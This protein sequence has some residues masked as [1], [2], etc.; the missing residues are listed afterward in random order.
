MTPEAFIELC[1]HGT[2]QEI[3]VALDAGAELNMR[4]EYGQTALLQSVVWYGPA[5]AELLL[6]AGT[7]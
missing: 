2:V 5:V 1:A 6:D 3:R 7:P 4:D